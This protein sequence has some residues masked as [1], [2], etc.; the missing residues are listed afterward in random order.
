MNVTQRVG[1]IL[2][3]LFVVAAIAPAAHA[4]T[5]CTGCAVEGSKSGCYYCHNFTYD[6]H[7]GYPGQCW[8]CLWFAY[9][10]AVAM[11][12]AS[13][14]PID[15]QMKKGLVI[16][17]VSKTGTPLLMRRSWKSYPMPTTHEIEAQVALKSMQ[18]CAAKKKAITNE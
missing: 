13:T 15:Q 11:K 6:P 1:I 14:M 7:D 12:L 3:M 5:Q 8:D 4:Q 10:K 16:T 9:P 18:S 2:L 17:I